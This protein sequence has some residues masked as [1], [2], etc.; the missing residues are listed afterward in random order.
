MKS[1]LSGTFEKKLDD[2][3][4]CPDKIGK[5]DEL[6]DLPDEISVDDELENL[7]DS[8]TYEEKNSTKTNMK[9]AP[10]GSKKN[11]N[12]ERVE[13]MEPPVKIEFH[14]PD[15]MD[16]KEF[17]RQIKGQERGLNRQTLA[18]NMDNRAA[19]E[20]RKVETGNGRD[21]ETEKK[22]REIVRQKALQSRIES[23]QR[24][25]M[26]YREAKAEAEEWIKTKDALHEPDHIA[27]GNPSKV[28][29]MGDASVN[30]SIG[31][32]WNTRVDQLADSVN[33]F[34]KG[35]TRGE[36][37]KIKMNVKLVVV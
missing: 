24:E 34:A 28:S 1:E 26:T 8:L 37:E 30:R 18:E 31:S 7:S 25:G 9:D 23:K 32:Q 17:N 2:L 35:R 10:D 27:G 13:R 4:S 20:K 19:F 21:Q 36:L 14:C 6:N 3:D 16:K 5:K 15:K 33:D 29:K 12:V 11:L 22:V